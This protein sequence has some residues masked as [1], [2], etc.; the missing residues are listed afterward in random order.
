LIPLRTSSEIEGGSRSDGFLSDLDLD[1]DLEDDVE[2][3]QDRD[4]S[5]TSIDSFL[6]C[7]EEDEV[8]G[9]ASPSTSTLSSACAQREDKRIAHRGGYLE[10]YSDLYDAIGDGSDRAGGRRADPHKRKRTTEDEF[11]KCM[12]ISKQAK[13]FECRSGPREMAREAVGSGGE[14]DDQRE[15]AGPGRRPAVRYCMDDGRWVL[16]SYWEGLHNFCNDESKWIIC[17]TTIS[18]MDTSGNRRERW[19][20]ITKASRARGKARTM[21]QD[22]AMAS[23]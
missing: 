16:R 3:D 17:C 5:D 10:Q 4:R 7:I 12:R 1:R 2:E 23:T 21:L 9:A 6:G 14:R 18:D 8:T 22:L 13:A 20:R 11:M 15:R 19:L